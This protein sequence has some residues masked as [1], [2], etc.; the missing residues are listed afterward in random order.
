MAG[1]RRERPD[2]A[3][4]GRPVPGGGFAVFDP[5]RLCIFATVSLIT[6][7]VGPL[8]LCGFAA[9]GLAGYVKA[10]RSGLLTSRCVLRDTRLIIG[11]LALLLIVGALA[12]SWPLLDRLG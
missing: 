12:A 10:R 9:L 11:Y 4:P 3:T 5:L 8:A 7:V 2:L 6:W 1:R